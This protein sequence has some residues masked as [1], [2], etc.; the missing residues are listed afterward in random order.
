MFTS[1][2]NGS[3]VTGLTTPAYTLIEDTPP[4]PQSRQWACSGFT[5]TQPGV[6][7]GSSAS[8]PWT[9]TVTRP[10]N[11]RQLN[12]VDSNNVLRSVAMNKYVVRLRKGLTVLAGQPSKVA[13]IV[14]EINIP[15]GADIADVANIKAMVSMWAGAHVQAAN[16]L[17]SLVT[18]AVI[19]A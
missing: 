6:D 16:N 14:E 9:L 3:A 19:P 1:P 4:N 5:G 7:S 15:A 11:V 12:A 2:I 13:S 18:T 10:A 17:V 8:R